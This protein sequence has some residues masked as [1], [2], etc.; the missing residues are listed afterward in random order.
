MWEELFK[1][2]LPARDAVEV[3]AAGAPTRWLPQP[4]D[5]VW[6]KAADSDCCSKATVVKVLNGCGEEIVRVKFRKRELDLLLSQTR[7]YVK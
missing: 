7:P 1:Q 6:A 3:F 4:G 5:V 2:Y